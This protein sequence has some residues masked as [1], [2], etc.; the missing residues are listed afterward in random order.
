MKEKFNEAKAEWDDFAEE[1][2]ITR[3]EYYLDFHENEIPN[4]DT[5]E[6]NKKRESIIKIVKKTLRRN[7]IFKCLT[8]NRGKGKKNG[9]KSSRVSIENG[10]EETVCN[11][12]IVDEKIRERNLQ[13]FSKVKTSHACED[14]TCEK[15]LCD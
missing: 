5:D 12:D 11:R 3:E 9:L 6:L 14:K 8:E 1:E 2:K 13:C 10:E 7:C 4:D 15:L